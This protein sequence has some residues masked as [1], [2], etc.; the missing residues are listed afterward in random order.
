MVAIALSSRMTPEVDFGSFDT[1]RF[2]AQQSLSRAV[3]ERTS[4]MIRDL[5][6]D[7]AMNELSS[8]EIVLRGQTK[9]YYYKQ[10]AYHAVLEI[11][12]DA[13]VFNEIEVI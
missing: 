7:L 6:I 12:P 1:P 9:S 13:E 8:N 5:R 2:E 3:Q 10:L 4:R 11:A